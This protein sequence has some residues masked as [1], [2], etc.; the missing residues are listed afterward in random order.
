[1]LNIILLF[2]KRL[3][4]RMEVHRPREKEFSEVNMHYRPN[5]DS[6]RNQEHAGESFIH[7]CDNIGVRHSVVMDIAVIQTVRVISISWI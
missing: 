1:M 6:L 5:N 3:Y 2:G 7:F 4:D